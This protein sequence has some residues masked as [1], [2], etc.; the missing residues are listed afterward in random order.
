MGLITF[1]IGLTDNRE[2]STLGWL[3]ETVTGAEFLRWIAA[4][5]MARRGGGRGCLSCC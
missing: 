1:A 5:V 4:I 3:D 2:C